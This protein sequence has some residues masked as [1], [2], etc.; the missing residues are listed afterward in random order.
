M[1]APEISIDALFAQIFANLTTARFGAE[2][3]S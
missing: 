3:V 1:N 2:T